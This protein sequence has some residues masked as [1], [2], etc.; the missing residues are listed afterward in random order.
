MKKAFLFLGILG[1]AFTACEEVNDLTTVE[2]EAEVGIDIPVTSVASTGAMAFDLKSV[3]ENTA[4]SNFSGE[5]TFSLA[6]NE[7]LKNYLSSIK[8]MTITSGTIE[9]QG[10][11]AGSGKEITELNITI[12]GGGLNKTISFTN[13]TGPYTIPEEKI[14]EYKPLADAIVAAPNTEFTATASGTA[15]YEVDATI[16]VKLNSS[17]FA[18]LITTK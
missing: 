9:V 12:A 5:N 8:D 16:K 6:D 2:V 17:V 7:G 10:L 18:G 11:T 1:I 4:V 14:T 13:I 3:A 15:N